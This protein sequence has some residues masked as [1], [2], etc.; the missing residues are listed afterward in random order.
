MK[1]RLRP[2]QMIRISIGSVAALMLTLV[3]FAGGAALRADSRDTV[4]D[5]IRVGRDARA[6]LAAYEPAL[7]QAEAITAR[8]AQD[9]TFAAS[10]LELA[11]KND[12]VGIANK[13]E[14]V[15]AGSKITVNSIQDFSMAISVCTESKC[16]TLCI[17]DECKT[18]SGIKSPVVFKE[19]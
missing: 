2:I 1:N 13:L 19:F 11:K 10:I 3:V 5:V 6:G 16:Y 8:L 18:P 7:R 9:R 4:D 12:K 15:A 14:A 17:G